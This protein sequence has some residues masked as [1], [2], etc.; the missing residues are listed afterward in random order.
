V[1]IYRYGSGFNFFQIYVI[2]HKKKKFRAPHKN[3][4]DKNIKKEPIRAP[5][6]DSFPLMIKYK[7][8]NSIFIDFNG[9]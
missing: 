2:G 7:K 3:K 5:Y 4:R 9:K 8:R 1:G 6:S